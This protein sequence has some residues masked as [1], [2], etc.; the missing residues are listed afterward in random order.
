MEEMEYF[1]EHE[2][3]E[4]QKQVVCPGGNGVRER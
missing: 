3:H 2:Q 1:L 4:P